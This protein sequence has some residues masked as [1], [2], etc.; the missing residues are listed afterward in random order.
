MSIV[1]APDPFCL[2]QTILRQH[3]AV[4]GK[5]GSGKT[6]TM[7]LI[8][9]HVAAEGARVCGLDPIKSDLW[10]LSAEGTLPGLPFHIL[11][12]PRGHV[13]LHAEAGAAIGELVGNGSLPL[14]VLDMANFEMGGLQQFFV[15]FAPALLRHMRGV[16][17]LVIEEA[18]E[19]A[20]KDRSGVGAENMAIYFAKKLATAGRSKGIRLIVA[21]QR[22]Q[23]LHN[24]VLGS[25]DTLIAHRIVAPADQEPVKKWLK[26]NPERTSFVVLDD[27]VFPD[28]FPDANQVHTDGF[29]GALTEEKADE[30]IR[31][32]QQQSL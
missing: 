15:H 8:V 31:K 23:A 16:L 32:L 17:Y 14:S 28:E 22:T 30:V 21:T 19:Y 5:T 10:G 1:P 25:C 27:D 13:P 26:A 4:V 11:G 7:K 9:E 3:I 29:A 20:P 6:S 24:A 18:H 12:G 2:P